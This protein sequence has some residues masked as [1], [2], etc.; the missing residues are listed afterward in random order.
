[1]TSHVHHKRGKDECVYSTI[2][3]PPGRMANCLSLD[4]QGRGHK[5][6]TEPEQSSAFLD[7]Y[8]PIYRKLSIFFPWTFLVSEDLRMSL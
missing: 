1:M 5:G 4:L 3:L 8:F 2:C 6:S 7:P